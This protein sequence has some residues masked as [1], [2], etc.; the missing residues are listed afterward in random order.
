MVCKAFLFDFDGV[1]VDSEPLHLETFREI[2]K[3]FGIVIPERRWYTEFVGVGSPH[4]MKTLLAEKGIVDEEKI[5][6]LVDARR[7]L[8]QKRIVEGRLQEKGGIRKF[9]EAAGKNGITMAVVSG[10]HKSNIAVAL[11]VLKM[12]KYFAIILGREDY[13]KRKPD[14]ECY[15]TGAKKLG[16]AAAECIVFEDSI[17]G[18]LAAKAAGMFLVAIEAPADVEE[19]GCKPDMKIKDFTEAK[20]ERLLR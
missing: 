19:A 18:C 15:L 16:V 14:P 9:L 2:V 1:L 5:R 8:F 12:E 10:G 3:P 11:Q 7:D 20:A 17:S 4:I 6:L 13:E